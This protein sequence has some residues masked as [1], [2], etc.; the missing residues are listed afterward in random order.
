[1]QQI[2]RSDFCQLCIVKLFV[3]IYIN[4]LADFGDG[5][6]PHVFCP[7]HFSMRSSD[8][9]SPAIP[10]ITA[11]IGERALWLLGIDFGTLHSLSV[12]VCVCYAQ[13]LICDLTI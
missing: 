7:C 1:M 6:A 10:K 8:Y 5:F 3:K 4:A 12:S 11:V 9:L 2:Q 13:S